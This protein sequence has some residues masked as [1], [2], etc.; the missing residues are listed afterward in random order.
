MTLDFDGCKL[1]GLVDTGAT[2]S[3]ISESLRRRLRKVLTPITA[4]HCV[5]LGDCR[6]VQPL[7]YCTGRV[8]IGAHLHVINFLVLSQCISDVVLGWDFLTSTEA[9]IDCSRKIL[10]LTADVSC[11]TDGVCTVVPVSVLMACRIPAHTMVATHV[12]IG[13]A[14]PSVDGMFSYKMD[15]FL[16]TSLCSPMSL[17]TANNGRAI[18]WITNS[19]NEDR[20]LA[21]GT[22]IGTFTFGNLSLSALV[23]SAPSTARDIPPST[24]QDTSLLAGRVSQDLSV[25]DQARFVD[26]LS[27]FSDLFDVS[28]APL[29]SCTTVTH[30]IQ[31]ENSPPV[32]CRPY[33]V[34]QAERRVIQ[35]HVREMLS[36]GII[37]ESNSPWSSPVVLVRKKDGTWRFCVDYRKLNSVTVKDVYP[38]PR[39][40][41]TL[42]SLHGARYFSSMDLRSGYWQIAVDE[43]DRE[44]TAFVTPDGLYE[45]RVMPF[46]LCNAPATFQRMM[47]M[48]LRSFRWTF[49]LCYL[50]DVVVFSENIDE[51]I[52][53]LR[54]VLECFRKAG[55]QLNAK[56]CTFGG[57]QIKILGHLVDKDGIH[58]DPDK[59]SAVQ[60]FPRPENQ[61]SL[62]SFLGLCSYFRRFIKGFAHIAD[63]L[64]RLLKKDTAFVWSSEQ[65]DSFL[66]LKA[67]LSSPPVLGHFVEGA[68]T[69]V[70]TDASGHGIGTVL[71]QSVNGQERVIA[72]ASR[73]LTDCERN[74]TITEKE[75]LAV[76]WA[77]GKFRPYIY[78]RPF[79]VITDHNALCWLTKMKNPTG[80]L[81]RWALKLQEY[82]FTI[83]YK[84]GKKHQDADSLSRHPSPAAANPS[85]T[86]AA[87]EFSDI[88]RQQRQDPA[89]VDI[90]NELSSTATAVSRKAKLFTLRGGILY[91][92]NFQPHGEQ[93]LLVIPRSLQREVIAAC[94]D[95]P[96]SGHLGLFKTY[97][98]LRN[99]FFWRGMYRSASKY[100]RSCVPCQRRKPPTTSPA[101]LLHPIPPA[102]AP[103]QRIGIDML[104]PFPLSS[105]GNR[106]VIASVDYLTRYAETRATAS[107]TAADVASFLLERI[108]L[109]HGA[110]QTLLSDRGAA[111]LSETVQNILRLSNIVHST[112]TPYHPQTNGLTE[113]LNR[114]LAEMM[115]MYVTADHKNWDVI[116]PYVTYAY[117]TA[118]QSTTG[119]S[120]YYLLYGRESS[121][122][123]D[124]LLPRVGDDNLDPVSAAAVC[125]AEDARQL[126]RLRTL[127]S[128]QQQSTRY[129]ASH[130][131]VSYAP[132]DM[133]WLWTPTRRVGRSEKL[134][135]RYTGPHKILRR[136]SDVNYQVEPCVPPLDRRTPAV[137]TAH[138]L[139]LKPFHEP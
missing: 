122:L 56:K 126:A 70:H 112:T 33:R 47:D 29:G 109:R 15:V 17:I 81:G 107:G 18:V 26:L 64:Q 102:E 83:N 80:R 60:Q 121:S 114:T 137:Q 45:F 27:D 54:A 92:E 106:W 123:L 66:S 41:D 89:L 5:K 104:G 62:R 99:R 94:H 101:G 118:R 97:S 115:S 36:H 3:C 82:D 52:Q 84:S 14:L 120:P 48:L 30:T 55:L 39:I 96:T 20:L 85:S 100:V 12:K 117:N 75:C 44:K 42:D 16:R 11:D 87:L 65:E 108:I 7:G 105:A 88:A 73:T 61:K 22:C 63:P 113:R 125:N 133:V 119:F 91:R 10:D 50:D 40:D 31:T 72:Y 13:T 32:H 19:S 24:K 76:V 43:H 46:G 131:P 74:Y 110:P 95:D 103:F 136:I 21:S 134:L 28:G 59:I 128:Q 51:H 38:L 69:E 132:G 138:V 78:G 2:I 111:F 90:F 93:W 53:R 135:P 6:A 67:L 4:D 116:L 129:N 130:R 25:Q 34:S 79:K 49:C 57:Q 1:E 124:C 58:P 86:V 77:L 23:P 139:R 37:Q 127:D 9:L 68:P 98:R 8:T 35:D 71:V